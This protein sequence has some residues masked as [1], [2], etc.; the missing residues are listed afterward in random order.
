MAD[1]AQRIAWQRAVELSADIEIAMRKDIANA[2]P[3]L[4]ILAKARDAAA[5]AIAALV[6]VDAEEPKE[7]RRLQNEAQRFTDMVR[8][9]TEMLAA[10]VDADEGIGDEERTE[11]IDLL[12]ESIE[13]A[14][15]TP[16]AVGLSQEQVHD[17]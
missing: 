1:P 2:G 10:G 16:E 12:A 17:A 5:E 4:G 9:L 7:I 14:D 15:I 13:D 6:T 3:L 8:W 11:L